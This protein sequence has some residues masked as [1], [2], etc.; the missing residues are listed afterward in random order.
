MVEHGGMIIEYE[1][2]DLPCGGSHITGAGTDRSGTACDSADSFSGGRI[3]P[4]HEGLRTVPREDS[5]FEAVPETY[6][7]EN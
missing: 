3:V 7:V 1:K 6:P 2:N 5:F 4:A